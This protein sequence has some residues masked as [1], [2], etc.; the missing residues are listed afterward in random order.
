VLDLGDGNERVVNCYTLTDEGSYL[1]WKVYG[2]NN[3]SDWTLLD[4][5]S[6][7]KYYWNAPSPAYYGMVTLEF[8]NSTAYRY[9]K[10]EQTYSEGGYGFRELELIE[11]PTYNIEASLSL[12]LSISGYLVDG[13]PGDMDGTLAIPL[14]I[15]GTFDSG[16]TIQGSLSIPLTISGTIENSY[17]NAGLVIPL[18][19]SGTMFDINYP[20]NG[21]LSLSLSVSGTVYVYPVYDSL[22]YGNIPSMEVSGEGYSDPSGY[23][24]S[25]IPFFVLDASAYGDPIGTFN[26]SLPAL[27]A[28]STGVDVSLG[29]ANLSIPMFRIS[30][31]VDSGNLATFNASLPFFRLSTTGYMDAIGTGDMVIPL[32]GLYAAIPTST[33][34]S[35]VINLLNKGLTEFAN[36][37][38]N[39]MCNFNGKN[40][41]ATTTGIHDLDSGTNDNGTKID[42]NFT[43]GYIDLQIKTKKKPREM[44][45]GCQIDGNVV[46]TVKKADGTEY[47]YKGESFEETER[48]VRV[49][50][51]KGIKTRYLSL[52]VKNEDVSTMELDAIRLML[53]KYEGRR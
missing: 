45:M 23:S 43:I 30:T 22:L 42:W 21:G 52:D 12:P 50:F 18:S 9:Y 1:S 15:S 20:I 6:A 48:G 40:L 38:F 32:F 28:S 49:K 34:K 31:V 46:V 7:D 29:I 11:I 41:G 33:Y 51:G 4:D 13:Y 35:L 27:R 44:W 37:N 25:V 16:K 8:S 2:S 26:R 39:S 10:W 47:E 17:I 36:Y 3:G 24:L 5:R 14:S 53:D 19:V